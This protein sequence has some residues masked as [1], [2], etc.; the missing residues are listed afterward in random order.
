MYSASTRARRTRD[1]KHLQ[2]PVSDFL[3]FFMVICFLSIAPSAWGT[4]HLVLNFSSTLLHSSGQTGQ[5]KY[6]P[7]IQ[8]GWLSRP[9][10]QICRS[11]FGQPASDT[12]RGQLHFHRS[13]TD[14]G[15]GSIYGNCQGSVV[16]RG[17]WEEGMLEK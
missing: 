8:Q 2:L 12:V 17:V 4:F 14:I 16:D 11:W 7:V 15:H 3:V 13:P 6:C 1:K 9:R 10:G 5:H